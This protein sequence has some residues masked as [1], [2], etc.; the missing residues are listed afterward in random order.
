MAK[1]KKK[2]VKIIPLGGVDGIGMNMTLFEYENDIIAVDCGVSFP[3]DD[4]LGVDLVIPDFSYLEKNAEK[5]KGLVITHG[6]EDHIGAVPFFMKKFKNVPVYATR[7]TLGI[8]E[9]KLAEHSIKNAKLREVKAGDVINIGVFSIEFINVNH[10]MPDSCAVCISTPCG[11]IMHTGDFKID[12][13]PVDEKPIDLCRFAELG[14]KGVKLLLCDSTNVE[15]AGYTPSESSLAPSFDRIFN[16]ESRRIIIATFSSNVHR[17]QQIINASEKFGRKVAITGRSMQNFFNAAVKLGYL[18]VPDGIMVDISKIKNLPPEKVTVV[19]T[20]SQGEPMSALY[21]MAFGEHN[22]V[23]IDSNDLVVLSSS[24]IP[25]NEKYITKIVNEL[26]KCKAGVI[27]YSNYDVHVSGHACREEIKIMHALVNAEYFVPVHGEY[28]HLAAHAALARELGT[29]PEKIIIPETGRV[30]EMTKRSI[31]P[32]QYVEA[33]SVMVDGS[34]VGDI[35][36]VVLRDRKHLAESGI[37]VVTAGIDTDAKCVSVSPEIITRGFVYEKQSEE[38]LSA[39]SDL[40]FASVKRSFAKG[41]R[42]V[43]VIKNRLRDDMADYVRKKTKR[44]P[45]I[46]PVVFEVIQ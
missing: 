15:R 38:L 41:C 1:Q 5:V 23:T 21:R 11:R 3:E 20:G 19:T 2:V 32:G 7:L 30:L 10:S 35:G 22:Y 8:I 6:H 40:T 31:K 43:N 13:T 28:K 9:G 4:M 34:G 24:A 46:V 44:R 42:D 17:V 27:T 29:P 33:G 37:I 26:Y 18:T 12:L 14:R 39:L 16:N 45:V 36:M 25:G